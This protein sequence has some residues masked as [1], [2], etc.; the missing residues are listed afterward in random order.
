MRLASR[1]DSLGFAER[2]RKNLKYIEE[3][4]KTGADVHVITQLVNSLLALIVF[5]WER[6][7]LEHVQTLS[8]A[9]LTRDGW[10]RWEIKSGSCDTLGQ[11][12]RYLRNGI[13]HGNIQFFSDNRY[14]NEVILEIANY[15]KPQASIPNWSAQIR[16]D[17][18]R[19]FC[20]R[21][22]DLLEQ[23]IG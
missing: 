7:F 5:P 10:P 13:A 14:L 19:E 6:L 8:L 9:D 17:Q 3:S 15:P 12:I 4:F 21:F 1:N 18:L 16:G 22:I 2:T 20:L 23:T 11:L